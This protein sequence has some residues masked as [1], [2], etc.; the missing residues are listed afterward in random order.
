MGVRRIQIPEIQA[1]IACKN[2]VWLV[3]GRSDR[4]IVGGWIYSKPVEWLVCLLLSVDWSD[5]W[6]VVALPAGLFVIRPAC[7]PTYRRLTIHPSIHPSISGIGTAVWR[8][9]VFVW[10]VGC[11]GATWLMPASRWSSLGRIS[12]SLSAEYTLLAYPLID[13]GTLPKGCVPCFTMPCISRHHHHQYT[14]HIYSH[15]VYSS[16]CS[17]YPV[18][19]MSWNQYLVTPPWVQPPPLNWN[20][21]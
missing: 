12:Y 9:S 15:V 19:V 21:G 16:E 4:W 8:I 20:P 5:R 2:C 13:L 14:V 18:L 17:L 3:R 10:P 11:G 6:S 1:M 7:Y